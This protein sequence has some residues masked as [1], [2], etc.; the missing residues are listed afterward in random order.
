MRGATC[1]GKQRYKGERKADNK[2][3]VLMRSIIGSKS[4]PIK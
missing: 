2:E 4:F 1:G 3:L